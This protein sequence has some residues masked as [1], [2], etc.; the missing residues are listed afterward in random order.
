MC[1]FCIVLF[2]LLYPFY[3][4]YLFS[5]KIWSKFVILICHV[6]TGVSRMKILTGKDGGVKWERR[7]YS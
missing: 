3:R 4:M 7:Y 5:K 1:P 6:V 2:I